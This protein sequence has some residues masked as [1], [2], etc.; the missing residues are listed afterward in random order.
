MTNP[1]F[2]ALVVEALEEIPAFFKEKL[3]NV[4]LVIEDWPERNPPG[5]FLLG[6]YQGVP[7]TAWGRGSVTVLPDKITIYQKP[8]EIV[9][10]GDPERIKT[11]AIETVQH[12][13][14]H[15]FGISDERLRELK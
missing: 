6:L 13:I 4:D 7:Q 12:E 2:E 15:H 14:A 1:E 8:I 9:S 5:Q 11:Q 3:D 10:A